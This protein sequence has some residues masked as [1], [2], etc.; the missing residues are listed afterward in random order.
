MICCLSVSVRS[1]FVM[2]V[3]LLSEKG[4]YLCE[5][6]REPT[7]GWHHENSLPCFKGN[8]FQAQANKVTGVGFW[9]DPEDGPAVPESG[10]RGVS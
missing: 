3:R 7:E 6:W 5:W 1:S 10:R 9:L 2:Q 4:G 8:S